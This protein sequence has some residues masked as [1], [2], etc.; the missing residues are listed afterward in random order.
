V[1]EITEQRQ[2]EERLRQNNERLRLLSEAAAVLLLADDPN[3]MLPALFDKIGPHLALDVYFHFLVDE[4]GEALRL[5][6]CTGIPEDTAQSC[7]RLE[8]GQAICG[9]SALTRQPVVASH[10]QQ[11]DDAN[12]QLVKSFGVRTYV[13]NPLLAGD[14]LLGTLSF[15]S[16]SRDQFDPGEL[17]FLQTIAHYV[18]FAYERARLVRELSE[19]DRRKDEFLATLAHE[20]RNPLAPLRNGLQLIRLASGDPGTLEQARTMMARQLGQL[21]RLVDDLMDLSRISRGRIE[22][23]KEPVRLAEVVAS[24]IETS[25]PL[26]EQ[27]GH[28]LTVTLPEQPIILDADLTRLAQ[29]FLNLLTNAAKYS[30][31]DGHISLT[32]ERQ[33]S[34][35]VVSV[36]DT[37]VGIAADQ[38]PRIFQMFTQVERSLE[39]AQ[40][41]LGIGLCL[42][43]RLVEMHGGSIEAKS[44]GPGRGSEFVVRLPVVF[45]ERGAKE[46]SRPGE[47]AVAKSLLRI[48][49]VDD[50]RDGADSLGMMLRIMG[51]DTRTAYDGR[52]GLQVAG[53]YRPDVILLDIG[54]PMLNGYET[55]RRIRA[56][57]W[58]NGIVVI[59]MTGW[60]QEEDRRRSHEAGFDHHLVKPVDP[61]ALMQLLSG[62]SNAARK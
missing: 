3:A 9:V 15:G 36:R 5:A 47:P 42:V 32:A 13:C 50:N 1:Q 54:L 4:R 14:K 49:I 16:R 39:K 48:L 38:L 18:A 52:D 41:G 7:A 12:A 10:M 56:Q 17:E 25:R 24:A 26:I 8:F 46:A 34:D 61:T 44:D 2:A 11:S 23:R 59:A 35:V 22:L 30:E 60:G 28:E 37:R 27:M 57:P 53:E 58:G 21:V 6:S 20:L 55:C 51:N 43:K 19:A 29:V 33:G 40:G 31:R 62:L 45:G